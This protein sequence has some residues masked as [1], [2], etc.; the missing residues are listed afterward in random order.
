MIKSP[1]E[2]DKMHTA[3]K[4]AAQ[5]LEIIAPRVLPDVT[6]NKLEQ[7]CHRFI[8]EDL[9]ATPSTLGQQD[10]PACICTSVNHVVC[11]GIPQDHKTLQNGDILNIDVTVKK[12]GFID[13]T[14]KMFLV[15]KV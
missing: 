3:G 7:L 14:S 13:D 10:F 2:I 15:G 12:D 6:T 1:K 8:I 5:V 4:L 9:Q 11:H